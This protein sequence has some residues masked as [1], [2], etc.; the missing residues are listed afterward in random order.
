M[1]CFDSRVCRSR[2]ATVG[3]K[4]KCGCSSNSSVPTAFMWCWAG[5]L[6]LDVLKERMSK[7]SELSTSA[8]VKWEVFALGIC[9]F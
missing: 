1:K 3:A 4:V 7:E 5:M 8:V 2:D 9:N 6:C